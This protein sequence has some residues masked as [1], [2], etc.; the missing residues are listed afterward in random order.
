[1]IFSD[2]CP[3]TYEGHHH[4][5]QADVIGAPLCDNNHKTKSAFYRGSNNPGRLLEGL[6]GFAMRSL[7]PSGRPSLSNNAPVPTLILCRLIYQSSIFL[8]DFLGCLA[9]YLA[10]GVV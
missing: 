6:F 8:S 3:R 7:R 2:V 4:V 10:K 1:M 9:Q 5:V